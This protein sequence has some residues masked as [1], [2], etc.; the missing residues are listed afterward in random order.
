MAEGI[1]DEIKEIIFLYREQ[2]IGFGE[3][4]SL[5]E[6]V[7]P[8]FSAVRDQDLDAHESALVE[9]EVA[10]AKARGDGNEVG[11]DE[12]YPDEQGK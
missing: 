1:R 5:L 11:S 8:G 9:A 6:G 4:R 3:A 12:P 10:L 7:I 2:L